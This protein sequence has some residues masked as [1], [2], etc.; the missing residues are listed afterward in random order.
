MKKLPENLKLVDQDGT[1]IIESNIKSAIQALVKTHKVKLYKNEEFNVTKTPEEIVKEFFLMHFNSTDEA[2]ATLPEG[3]K[4][5]EG[6]FNAISEHVA[7]HQNAEAVEKEQKASAAEAKKALR[8]AE[9][10]AR[11][12]KE[13]EFQKNQSLV[14]GSFLKKVETFDLGNKLVGAVVKQVKLP[15]TISFTEGG[16]G[17][18]FGDNVTHAQIG[19]ATASI[20]SALEGQQNLA[21][22]LQFAIGDLINKGVE[23][24]AYKTKSEA[25]NHIVNIVKEKAGKSYEPGTLAQY[26]KM[27]ERISVTKR[28]LG[29]NPSLYLQASKAAPPKIL[30]GSPQAIEKEFEELRSKLVEGIN[31]G[32][33]KKTK[34][35]DSQIKT[36]KE[37]KGIAISGGASSGKDPQ[38]EKEVNHCLLQIFNALFAKSKLIGI[39]KEGVVTYKLEEAVAELGEDDLDNI[40]KTNVS[41]IETL[42]K[43]PEKLA[44]VLK[45]KQVDKDGKDV[46]SRYKF[47]FNEFK[48]KPTQPAPETKP[49][50]KVTQ[51]ESPVVEETEIVETSEEDIELNEG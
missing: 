28:K 13:K 43:S 5:Y 7:D 50:D 31:Q 42:T 30:G 2:V 39:E 14:E 45:G 35:I 41:R 8:E 4:E 32:H 6:L 15:S 26:A 48:V 36:Y 9:T 51:T 40:I 27:A 12:E 16:M 3:Y 38:K 49:E 20:I 23:K 44:E 17:L 33:Y 11:E 18:S 25:Q 19:E 24:G 46:T 37:S 34:D 10:K 22:S 1:T 47:P 21:G 29:V